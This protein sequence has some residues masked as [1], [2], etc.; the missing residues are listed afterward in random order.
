M[1]KEKVE[2]TQFESKL[3][4]LE[5]KYGSGSVI[6]GKDIQD[7]V[8]VVNSGS[9]TLNIATSIGGTPVGKCIE[10]LGM[11]SSGKSTI[12]LHHIAEFQRAGKKCVLCD[13]EQSFDKKYATAIGVNVDDIIILQPECLEDG[14]N[15]IEEL[16]RT[17]E[18][19]LVV[20][21]SHTA[22]MPKKVVEGEVG[23]ATIGLQARINS[24]ALGKIKPL[25]MSNNCTLIAISQIRQ[26]I[27]GYGDI[28]ISTGGLAY[29]FY[30]DM[31]LKVSKIVDKENGLNKT[32]VEVIK[33]KCGVPF[34][35]AEFQI[36]WGTGIDRVQEIIDLGIEFKVLNKAGSWFTLEDGNKLQGDEALK[37]FFIDNPEYSQTIETKVLEAIK[38]Q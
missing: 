34:G 11:E 19:G 10:L 35:K 20:I 29:K 30:S 7:K 32:I 4:E 1:A 23:Q 17:G 27:G 28:N 22:G 36:N 3:K 33:N 14:Y 18:V 26:N 12:T 21:D 16:I 24:T 25:L 2:K 31:R 8:E 6:N 5:K 13:F 38:N 9:L 37:Q 15:L